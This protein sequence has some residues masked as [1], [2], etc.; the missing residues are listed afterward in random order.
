MTE[1]SAGE[2]I[3]RSLK[4]NGIDYVFMNSGSDFAPII[5]A[6]ASADASTIPEIVTAPHENV[7]VA[8]AHGYSLATGRMQAAAVHVNVGLANAVMGLL[9]AAS[10]DVDELLLEVIQTEVATLK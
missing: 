10:D 8:M 7:A 5:E 1:I 6:L 3:L 2:A 9:N 4:N